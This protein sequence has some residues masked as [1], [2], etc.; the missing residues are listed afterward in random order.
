MA[1]YIGSKASVINSGVENKKVI[2]ATAGQTSFT[3]LTYSPNRVHV[4]QNGVRLV[5]GT[6]YTATDG[7]SLTL[8][9]GAAVNDQVVVVSYSGFQTSD[10]VSASAGG[11]FTGDVNFTGAFTSQ[12][13]DDNATSTAMTLDAS[14]NLLVGKTTTA[15][16]TTGSYIAANGL[17]ALTTDSQRPLIL[18]RK[19]N[20]GDL[21]EFN[22]DGSTV[23]SIGVEGGDLSI[24]TGA[25]GIQ[26]RS[27]DPA[28]RGFNMTTNSPSDATVNLGRVNT[29]F[30]DLYLSG[31]V[32]L[33]GTGSANK[34][35]DYEEGSWSPA[36]G[37][38]S[39]PL[40]VMGTGNRYTKIGRQVIAYFDITWDSG[41]STA[42]AANITGLPFTPSSDHEGDGAATIGYITGSAGVDFVIHCSN[43]NPSF[44]FYSDG[45]SGSSTYAQVAGRRIAGYIQYYTNA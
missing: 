7:T 42:S 35:D 39:N 10:T 31:G 38:G 36:S 40:T 6:D 18:N 14:G 27:S 44:N 16:S 2:T 12:G 8:T 9:V 5:D 20:D 1:G 28:I 3:G 19:A 37:N 15:L 11:T 25:S 34:L 43:S 45:S 4:F 23:G 24:G 33:G 26:F 22:K 29:R 21:I 17:T 13:I 41:N 30:K 32:Y